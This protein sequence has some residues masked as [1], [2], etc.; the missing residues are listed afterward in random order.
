MTTGSINRSNVA[1][2]RVELL[3]WSGTD[4][5]R[6][7]YPKRPVVTVVRDGVVYRYK[8]A[9]IGVH[10]PAKREFD[11]PHGFTKS[12]NLSYAGDTQTYKTHQCT[13]I[14]C[15]ALSLGYTPSGMI[16]PLFQ[17]GDAPDKELLSSNDKL[18]VLAGLR[19]KI[20][21]SDFNMSVFLGE[22]HQTLGLIADSATRIARSLKQL[23]HGDIVGAAKSLVEGTGRKLRTHNH[24]RA[25]SDTMSNNWLELQYGWLP[26]IG[27]THDAAQS[28]AHAMYAPFQT[29]FRVGRT[30]ERKEITTA[31][32]QPGLCMSSSIFTYGFRTTQRYGLT[33]IIK[34]RPSSFYALGLMNPEI[35][36]WELMPWSFV[37]DWFLPIGQYLDARAAASCIAGTYI[38]S[39]RINGDFM[40]CQGNLRQLGAYWH[41]GSFVRTVSTTPPPVPLPRFVGLDKALS[42][43]HCVNA[44]ALLQGLTSKVKPRDNP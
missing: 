25:T 12:W 35:V 18:K 10:R 11:T 6:T 21:G 29:T 4:R 3:S 34:E 38:T 14:T 22:S 42:W 2:R 13:V 27:D 23:K 9:R 41:R 43:K 28:L 16:T 33:L 8:S 26:L 39:N 30:R 44:L 19:E 1:A 31:E 15:T 24:R 40:G 5:P 37:I 36:A 32:N 7:Q 20:Y 17:N